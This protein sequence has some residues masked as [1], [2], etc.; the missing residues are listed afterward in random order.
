MA[1]KA[2]GPDGAAF[3]L[4]FKPGQNL[5]QAIWLSGHVAPQ[6]LCGGSGHCGRCKIRF[7]SGAPEPVAE[8]RA[9]LAPEDLDAGWRLACHHPACDNAVIYLPE[10]APLACA[11]AVKAAPGAVALGIDLGTTSIQWRAVDADDPAREIASGSLLN[12]Q[13]GAGADVISRVAYARTPEGRATLA[14]LARE[15]ISGIF[16]SLAACGCSIKGV[17]VAANSAMTEILLERDVSGLAAAPYSLSLKGGAFF[18]L[19]GIPVPVLIPPLPAP[20]VGGDIS[21]GLLALLERG[22]EAPFM[23]IDL[24]TNAEL[25]LYGES[26][27]LYLASAP[28]GPAMEGIGPA[29]GQLAGE[30]VIAAFALS[31][32]GLQASSP[33]GA[34]FGRW[35]GISATGYLS[36]LSILLR[37]GLMGA[38]GQFIRNPASPLGRKLSASIRNGRLDL[39]GDLYLDL[40]DIEL[41]LKV[42]AAL[43]TAFAGLLRAAGGKAGELA[44]VWLAGALGEHC[45]PR[46]LAETGFLPRNAMA[47]LHACGNT[48]LA[49]AC[50]LAANPEKLA[51]LQAICENARIIQLTDDPD[52][53]SR[54]F[55]AMTWGENAA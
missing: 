10:R 18:D 39:P 19:A 32:Q 16:A 54:Y 27:Q 13:A 52:F 20:F 48:S 22:A 45:A 14:R 7:E 1:L 4:A 44:G 41:L 33:G 12:P 15:A 37:S 46:D 50:L 8:D 29:C 5:A 9:L 17:C 6:P 2:V 21:A 26:G 36:L 55:A 25:A 42:K 34:E 40:A 30:N 28:L 31:P 35:E 24:G 49:G 23:L 53:N 38:N 3:D 43:A 11:K 47:K 51:P